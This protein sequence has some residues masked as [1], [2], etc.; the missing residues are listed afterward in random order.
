MLKREWG[1]ESNGKLPHLFIPSKSC[2]LGY[3]VCIGR[4]AF[5]QN[6]NLG[7]CVRSEKPALGQNTLIMMLKRLF[8]LPTL[9][10]VLISHPFSLTGPLS[11]LKDNIVTF[12]AVMLKRSLSVHTMRR[13]EQLSWQQ[14]LTDDVILGNELQSRRSAQLYLVNVKNVLM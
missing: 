2:N 12:V 14:K 10:F 7:S 11:D 4:P 8:I 9:K 13:R 5:G 1:V 3:C 6:C